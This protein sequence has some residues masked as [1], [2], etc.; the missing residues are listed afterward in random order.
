MEQGEKLFSPSPRPPL[1]AEQVSQL[2]F[3]RV[4]E[5]K[6]YTAQKPFIESCTFSSD[7][8]ELLF[9]GS[10]GRVRCFDLANESVA[11]HVLC[12]G[13]IWAVDCSGDDE[14]IC[15]CDSDKQVSVW[16]KRS[17][18]CLAVHLLHL[19]TVWRV[20]FTR[21]S[22]RVV[23]CSSDLRIILWDFKANTSRIFSGHTKTIED[24]SLSRDGVHLA[25][26]SQDQSIKIWKDLTAA[27]EIQCC[28]VLN[29]HKSRVT[30]CSFAPHRN[31]ILAST[32][33]DR[34]II[35]WDTVRQHQIT[36]MKGHSGIIW[37]SAFLQLGN[38][39]I[40][41]SCSSDHTLR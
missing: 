33:A 21:D 19:D 5:I 35:V 36:R 8:K 24:I 28:S 11:E 13:I 40:L 4:W 18:K 30:S 31:G 25:S 12:G 32:S 37:S 22:S 2:Q 7:N 34:V 23:S 6:E 29:G 20:K 14:F 39:D 9:A 27:G 41:I 3:R 16:A 10:D 38:L 17:W 26:C 1:A 15:I